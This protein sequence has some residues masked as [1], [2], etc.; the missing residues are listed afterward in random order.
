MILSICLKHV[1]KTLQRHRWI[2]VL[3]FPRIMK[4]KT[5]FKL[6]CKE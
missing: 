1:Y 6:F 4:F 2:L 5:F 3:A